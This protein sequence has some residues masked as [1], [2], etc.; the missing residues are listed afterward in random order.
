MAIEVRFWHFSE[1]G[2]CPLARRFWRKSR[3]QV[4]ETTAYNLKLF[5]GGG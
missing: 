2:R 3:H 5:A 4:Q 1:L